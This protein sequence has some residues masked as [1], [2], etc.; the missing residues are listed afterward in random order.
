MPSSSAPPRPWS[1]VLVA[2]LLFLPTPLVA[3]FPSLAGFLAR[4]DWAGVPAAVLVISAYLLAFMLLASA[5]AGFAA[6]MEG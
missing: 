4:D 2:A 5:Y 1:R 6:R 3:A